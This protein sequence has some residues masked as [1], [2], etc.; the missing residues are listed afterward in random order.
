M[1][2]LKL[3]FENLNSLKGKTAINF[4]EAPLDGSG[5]FVITG[6]TGAGKSTVLDAITL[7][8]YGKIAR[9]E[10][11][12]ATASDI[13]DVLT[14]GTRYAC[15]E[16][17][18][19]GTDGLI[20]RAI[21]RKELNRNNNFKPTERT[22][23]QLNHI[24]EQE[25]SILSS[26]ISKTS[27]AVVKSIG[28]DYNQFIRSVLLAQGDFAQ[29]LKD[30]K[31]R[32]EILERMTST[33]MYSDISKAAFERD[34]QE[35]EAHKRLVQQLEDLN[36][37][38]K[39]ELEALQDSLL[40]KDEEKKIQATLNLRYQKQLDCLAKYSD[41][42][43]ELADLLR[44]EA[45]LRQE[46]VLRQADFKALEQHLQIQPFQSRILDMQRWLQEITVLKEALKG[47]ENKQSALNQEICRLEAQKLEAQNIFTV[48]NK[49][50]TA[51]E[52]VY[53]AVLQLDERLVS[54]KKSLQEK[55]ETGKELKKTVE[56]IEVRIAAFKGTSLD[57]QKKITVWLDWLEEKKVYE[58]LNDEVTLQEI[59][60]CA[61]EEKNL[62][63][64]ISEAKLEQGELEKSLHSLKEKAVS[65]GTNQAKLE[66][67][68]KEVDTEL[69]TSKAVFGIG[70]EAVSAQEALE[71]AEAS[72]EQLTSLSQ[73]K[74]VLEEVWKKAEEAQQIYTEQQSQQ[75][76]NTAKQAEL[77]KQIAEQKAALEDATNKR[78]YAEDRF[79]EARRLH[80]YEA[81]RAALKEGEACP[82]CLATAH[83]FRQQ[84]LDTNLALKIAIEHKETTNIIEE[85]ATARLKEVQVVFDR[86]LI[87]HNK[88]AAKFDLSAKQWTLAKEMLEKTKGYT[89]ELT[90]STLTEASEELSRKVILFKETLGRY[91]KQLEIKKRITHELS[92][93]EQQLL[94]I[95]EQVER[96][97]IELKAR[98]SKI[99]DLSILLEATKSTLKDLLAP[100]NLPEDKS[101]IEELNT[102]YA[103]YKKMYRDLDALQKEES[104]T[105][106]ELSNN[107]ANLEKDQRA[108]LQLKSQ[109]QL[110]SASLETLRKERKELFEAED[111]Q[112]AYNTLQ[113][114]E[115]QATLNLKEA[116]TVYTE[117]LLRQTEIRAT[118]ITRQKDLTNTEEKVIDLEPV[119][120][121]QLQELNQSTWQTASASL[122]PQ[123]KVDQI[124]KNQLELKEALQAKALEIKAQEGLQLKLKQQLDTTLSV[125]LSALKILKEE[126][127]LKQ[128]TL[129]E[130]IGR[131]KELLRNQDA[132]RKQQSSL[133][134]ACD[135]QKK[136]HQRWS[137]MRSLIGSK[138]GSRFRTFAQSITLVRLI[139][140]ANTHLQK[141][142]GG[143][144]LLQKTPG[145]ELDLSVLDAD[146]ANN[147]RSLTTLSGGET[148]LVSLALALG[149]SDMAAKHA[150]LQSI[151]I[152][153]GFGTLDQ[154]MLNMALN[155]LQSLQKEGKM[156]GVISHV[157]I[158]KNRIATQVQ[159]L[160]KGNGLSE[161]KVI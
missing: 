145:E 32:G 157:E 30:K 90:L 34:K 6:D 3:R 65:L 2:I 20:Y 27:A 103:H 139:E 78:I 23:T 51:F 99:T 61:T 131:I 112:L 151:F 43:K 86:Q 76:Q 116:E 129:L 110:E 42:E 72:F 57:R 146:Q 104:I 123:H 50:R 60:G 154:D 140:L 153:E 118:I 31:N 141:F 155:T 75:Q 53:K 38:T 100:F 105:Q 126:L 142:I 44:V 81:A 77:A 56:S 28:L 25:G 67:Q 113:Q 36:L 1:K 5:I 48:Q 92:L 24:G 22:L 143:R 108:L 97:T 41:T 91:K 93:I 73:E 135:R 115:E 66:E 63:V 89:P 79:E 39:E 9:Y 70:G 52:P 147:H 152:D 19:E 82:L 4:D 114:E 158:L 80:Q 35:G 62:Q 148:F 150:R 144:Y 149:L 159:V 133:Q 40:V 137:F 26:G 94:S 128:N 132:L 127:N 15:A 49:K 29:F 87:E 16:V 161:I 98:S 119:L 10:N 59:K 120:N 121:K 18:Y 83:P 107:K 138:D 156:I 117:R 130:D 84:S 109:Y 134:E 136:E 124:Q 54:A 74:K 88:Q 111:I 12:G 45:H 37:C 33:Q 125:D 14:Y 13:G 71:L 69:T 8:L 122:L 96:S 64:R 21:W 17:D 55:Q 106:K 11:D 85:K 58:Q 46:K 160:K 68:R 47:L 95:K 7:A 102:R 101:V